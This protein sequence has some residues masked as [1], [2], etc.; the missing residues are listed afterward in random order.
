MTAR[1]LLYA[2]RSLIELVATAVP[3]AAGVILLVLTELVGWVFRVG[4]TP[5]WVD[6]RPVRGR[7]AKDVR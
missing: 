6:A 2:G 7:A 5:H 3:L 1:A 4:R